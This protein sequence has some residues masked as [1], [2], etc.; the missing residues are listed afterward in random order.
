MYAEIHAL[1]KNGT[2]E[3][4]ELPVGKR[5]VGCK[6]IFTVKYNEDESVSRFK[7]RLV[8]K[9]FTQSYGIDYE[10]I[11]RKCPKFLISIDSFFVN[12]II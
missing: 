12:N 6:W 1:E 2:S 11:V 8:A 4:S 9:G 5:P 10:E 7:A 3:I